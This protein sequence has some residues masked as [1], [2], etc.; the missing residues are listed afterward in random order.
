MELIAMRDEELGLRS[1]RQTYKVSG[2]GELHQTILSSFPLCTFRHGSL[3]AQNEGDFQSVPSSNCDRRRFKEL[4]YLVVVVSRLKCIAGR[5]GRATGVSQE[6]NFSFLGREG[7]GECKQG[8][9]ISLA[10]LFNF[11]AG[12]CGGEKRALNS[13]QP[14]PG[15][16]RW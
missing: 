3:P 5:E 15:G 16:K 6:K 7:S 14:N 9:L 4:G 11:P 2:R 10:P 12:D 1:G 13:A 8:P